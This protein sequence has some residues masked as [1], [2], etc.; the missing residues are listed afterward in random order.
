MQ[1][2]QRESG[3]IHKLPSCVLGAGSRERAITVDGESPVFWLWD[4][5][6]RHGVE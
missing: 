5:G 1:F 2:L 3:R 6:Y 4:I